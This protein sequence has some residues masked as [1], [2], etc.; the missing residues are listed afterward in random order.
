MY[1]ITRILDDGQLHAGTEIATSMEVS[2]TAVWKIVQRLKNFGV[3]IE[4]HHGGYQLKS[5]LKLLDPRLI[6]QY[7]RHPN[8]KL[9]VF[10]TLASTNDYLKTNATNTNPYFCITEYQTNGRGRMGRSWISPFGCNLYFSLSYSFTEDISELSG[11]SLV[12][13]ISVVKAL[14][15]LDANIPFQ[16]KWPND[17]TVDAKKLAGVLVEVMAEANGGCRAIIGVGLNVNMLNAAT[18]D[19]ID[20]PW[21]SLDLLLHKQ[22]DRNP[23]IASLID[24]MLETIAKFRQSGLQPFIPD[25]DAV[26]ALA[27]K[28][29]ALLCAGSNIT[30][31]A[32]GIDSLGRLILKTSTAEHKAF[33]SGDTTIVKKP[34]N[35]L[36][37]SFG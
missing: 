12:I 18:D 13:G 20:R 16:L 9:D 5:P 25:W 32:C 27:G 37:L 23:L 10:E 2:R 19:A 24:A 28:N 6:Q 14:Q 22:L 31:T 26:D 36:N 7:S 30:G 1:H 21:T 11:L 3:A 4:G 33:S 35:I 17:I 34:E 29:I 8:L 15:S